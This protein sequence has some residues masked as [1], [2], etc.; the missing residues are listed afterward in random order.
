VA[1]VVVCA[2]ITMCGYMLLKM[3]TVRVKHVS[4]RNHTCINGHPIDKNDKFCNSCGVAV[5]S[6]FEPQ[7]ERSNADVTA[8]DIT[9]LIDQYAGTY[10][11]QQ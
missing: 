10:E 8:Q 11:E 6:L 3:K 2:P 9:A 5:T 4:V 7:V 1:L